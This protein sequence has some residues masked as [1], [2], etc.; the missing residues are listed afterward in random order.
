MNPR[1]RIFSLWRAIL[2]TGVL[3]GSVA[4]ARCDEL[5]ELGHRIDAHLAALRY[6]E[7]LT[8]ADV[9]LAKTATRHGPETLEYAGALSRKA[10]VL[11]VQGR[12]RRPT[13]SSTMLCA[14]TA[15]GCRPIT[16]K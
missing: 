6:G 4:A 3:L 1:K 2:A 8:A 10:T 13:R 9:L 14:S 11:H 16:W 15:C 5:A 12:V 7:A